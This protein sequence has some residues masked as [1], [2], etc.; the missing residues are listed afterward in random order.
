M[1]ETEVKNMIRKEI[2]AIKMYQQAENPENAKLQLNLNE[3]PYEI[4]DV[5]TVYR[6]YPN[7]NDMHMYDMF[8]VLFYA[9]Q[10]NFAI[11]RG[12]YDSI[13]AIIKIFC[14][15]NKDAILMFDYDFHL[16]ESVAK[17]NAVEVK[18]INKLHINGDKYELKFDADKIIETINNDPTIK[19]FF[20]SN[21]S[22][23]FG[24]FISTDEIFKVINGVKNCIVVVDEAYIE[25]SSYSKNSVAEIKNYPNLVIMRSASQSMALAGLRLGLIFASEDIIS[26]VKQIQSPHLIPTPVLEVF[27]NIIPKKL[28][29]IL[30]TIKLIEHERNIMLEELPTIKCFK[31]VFPSSTN[32][33]F[34]IFNK[35]IDVIHDY[36][37]K[38]NIIIEPQGHVIENGATITIGAGEHNRFVM[39]LVKLLK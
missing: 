23:P 20:F 9:N 29:N 12:S 35:E 28:N 8:A 4:T 6:M 32:F 18:K 27:K 5:Q 19:V 34:V 2:A 13:D 7:N 15:P 1:K 21:P 24:E 11:N 22:V 31:H 26:I 17:L 38:N 3:N 33:I 25:F 30:G 36:L 16:Y 39:D 37:L 14:T 10:V